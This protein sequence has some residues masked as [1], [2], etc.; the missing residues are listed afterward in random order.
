MSGDRL[1]ALSDVSF[2]HLNRSIHVKGRRIHKGHIFGV[3]AFL[4]IPLAIF[5]S[6]ALAPLFVLTAVLALLV[7]YLEQGKLPKLSP[8]FAALFALLA[9]WGLASTI[10]SISP[11]DSIGLVLPLA[12]TFLGGLVLV[13]L[14]TG[15]IP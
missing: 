10:W 15:T 8:A 4:T 9:I 5:I 1:E 6:K 2:F 13:S 3:A 11:G 14:A 7:D 12:G